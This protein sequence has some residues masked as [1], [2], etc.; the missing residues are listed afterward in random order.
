MQLFFFSLFDLASTSSLYDSITSPQ[1]TYDLSKILAKFFPFSQ[2]HMEKLQTQY[3][4]RTL[5]FLHSH[6]HLWLFHHSSELHFLP[7]NLHVHLHDI[8]FVNVFDSFIPITI[9][10]TL[11]FKPTVLFG[12]H[13]LFDKSLRVS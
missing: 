12:I 9:L 3:F 2:L 4:S 7:S 13:T 8:C 10:G 11:R 5:R 6:R 1:I